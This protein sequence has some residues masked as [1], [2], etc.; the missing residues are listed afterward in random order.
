MYKVPNSVC[1]ALVC[2]TTALHPWIGTTNSVVGSSS[3]C[4]SGRYFG[5]EAP[6]GNISIRN[7][8]SIIQLGFKFSPSPTEYLLVASNLQYYPKC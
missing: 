5:S 2:Q 3:S 4:R 8:E 1:G 7:P 6:A